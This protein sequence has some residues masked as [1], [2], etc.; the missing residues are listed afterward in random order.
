MSVLQGFI[1]VFIML[2]CQIKEV[3]PIKVL[4]FCS[5]NNIVNCSAVSFLFI[6]S[7]IS[8]KECSCVFIFA[9]SVNINQN[10]TK[11]LQSW[12]PYS[13]FELI[14]NLVF[15]LCPVIQNMLYF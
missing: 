2:L 4:A 3:F 6:D 5:F 11:Y 8:M 13:K 12:S 15:S 10:E 9:L 1:N 14:A 7:E